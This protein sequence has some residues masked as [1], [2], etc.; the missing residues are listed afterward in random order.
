V[1][2]PP[3]PPGAAPRGGGAG[4]PSGSMLGAVYRGMESTFEAA[5]VAV[6]PTGGGAE[7]VRAVGPGGA[8]VVFEA[9]AGKYE[10]GA[11]VEV[12]IGRT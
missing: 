9:F 6:S 12:T 2:P 7:V 10:G 5:V 3:P 4:L 8:E 11:V 1:P